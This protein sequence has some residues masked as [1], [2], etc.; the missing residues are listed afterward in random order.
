M[1]RITSE[2]E[3]ITPQKAREYLELNKVNR[4]LNKKQVVFYASQ[5]VR[6]QW[7]L[8]GEA[9]VF[10]DD[11]HLLNGQHRLRAVETAGIPVDFLVVRGC[12][13]D[14]FATYDT[15]RSRTGGDALAICNIRN[16]TNMAALIGKYMALKNGNSVIGTVST[17][18]RSRATNQDILDEFEKNIELYRSIYRFTDVCYNQMRLLAKSDIGGMYAYLHKELGYKTSYIESFFR[19]LFSLENIT[20]KTISLLQRRLMN[21]KMSKGKMTSKYRTALIIK[22]WNCYVSNKELKT[23]AWDEERESKPTFL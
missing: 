18:S 7:K 20:N 11:G 9:I 4:P 15:G 21:E 1:N 12:E 5:M 13:S 10:A 6:G 19:M 2:V 3:T 16:S 8:N 17:R 22:T 23:L 14:V